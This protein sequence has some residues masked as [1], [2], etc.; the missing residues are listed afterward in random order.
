MRKNNA[1]TN[2]LKEITMKR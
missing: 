1:T 2:H